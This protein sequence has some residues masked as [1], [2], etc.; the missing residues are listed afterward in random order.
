MY[1]T[2]NEVTLCKVKIIKNFFPFFI[3]FY[4]QHFSIFS[5]LQISKTKND[6][7]F[8]TNLMV[9]FIFLITNE[10]SLL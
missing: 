7:N 4:F 10:F 5:P 3:Y 2:S 9:K 8:T 1:V 6:E